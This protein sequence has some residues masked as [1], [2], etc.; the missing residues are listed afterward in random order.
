M[1]LLVP[2]A[3]KEGFAPPPC[4]SAFIPILTD[5]SFSLFI[6]GE[7]ERPILIDDIKYADPSKHHPYDVLILK[8]FPDNYITQLLR[9]EH[10]LEYFVLLR[11]A[12]ALGELG[13]VPPKIPWPLPPPRPYEDLESGVEEWRVA[14]LQTIDT[15][16][17]RYATGLIRCDAPPVKP[18]CCRGHFHPL[19]GVTELLENILRNTTL[20]TLYAAWNVSKSW[21]DITKLILQTHCQ[22]PHPCLPIKHGDA[23]EQNLMWLR[24]SENQLAQVEDTLDKMIVFDQNRRSTGINPRT[25]IPG[26]FTQAHELSQ[27]A[28]HN[29]RAL[30]I[31]P[32][33]HWKQLPP[34]SK[35][36]CWAGL[37]QFQFNSRFWLF[38][39]TTYN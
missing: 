14:S 16:I 4:L 18:A 10:R 30:S 35:G 19:F 38:L 11:D 21:R 8:Y 24:P 12:R 29:I 9:Y 25:F 15:R 31:L 1:T 39:R 27:S 20:G 37:S 34:Q 7:D 36:P 3:Y 13:S 17:A 33:T 6:M 28:L 23:I 5:Y 22:T 2:K 32:R 26:R